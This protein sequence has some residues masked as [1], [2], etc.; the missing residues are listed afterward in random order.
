MATEGDALTL[1]IL[2]TKPRNVV[3]MRGSDPVASDDRCQATV[4][5]T[6]TEHTL[7]V[8]VV[9]V[10]DSGE[11]AA[12]VNDNLYGIMTSAC[13]VTIKGKYQTSIYV[14]RGFSTSI[15]DFLW[16]FQGNILNA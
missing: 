5:S 11:Y 4:D 1:R 16:N 14:Q 3:W 15:C 7:A 12:R 13:K 8:S 10:E 2:L 9:K 6:G